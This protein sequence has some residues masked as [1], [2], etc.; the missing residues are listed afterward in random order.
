MLS[1]LVRYRLS[2]CRVQ[3]VPTVELFRSRRLC[4][5]ENAGTAD[6]LFTFVLTGLDF[7]Q[8][9]DKL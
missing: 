7:V 4:A 9:L 2:P 3:L 6:K 8:K 5:A 1:K